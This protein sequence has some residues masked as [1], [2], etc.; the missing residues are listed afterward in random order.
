MPPPPTERPGQGRFPT[1][2]GPFHW[3]NRVRCQR[4]VNTCSDVN[5]SSDPLSTC[6]AA[7]PPRPASPQVGSIPAKPDGRTSVSNPKVG[8]PTPGTPFSRR[9]MQVSVPWAWWGLR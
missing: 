3:G 7:R 8:V 4:L 6:G 1:G 5:V 2:A 9:V